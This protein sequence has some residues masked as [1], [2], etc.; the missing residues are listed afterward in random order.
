MTGEKDARTI[1]AVAPGLAVGPGDGRRR[2]LDEGRKAR[3]RHEAVIEDDGEETGSR[4]GPAGEV[5]ERAIARVDQFFSGA[6]KK[7]GKQ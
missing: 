1:P 6:L 7:Y 2:I 4:E 5:I 3:L